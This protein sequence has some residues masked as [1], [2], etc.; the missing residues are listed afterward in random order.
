MNGV[1]AK[2]GLLIDDSLIFPAVFCLVIYQLIKI[3]VYRRL[4]L[5]KYKFKKF[6]WAAPASHSVQ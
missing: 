3:I 4:P 6:A 5:R 2:G 1:N